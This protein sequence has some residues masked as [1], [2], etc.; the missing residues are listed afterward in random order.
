VTDVLPH[1]E[2][3]ETDEKVSMELRV[4]ATGAHLK[5]APVGRE[6]CGGC[7]YYLEPTAE[8]SYCWHERLRILVGSDW[9]CQWWA[10]DGTAHR[11]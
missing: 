8:L 4:L 5:G 3:T 6:S 2:P 1:P 11:A 9:W 10:T 7:L